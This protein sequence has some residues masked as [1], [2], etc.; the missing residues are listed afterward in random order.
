MNELH[1]DVRVEDIDSFTELIQLLRPRVV[2]STPDHNNTLVF[3]FTAAAHHLGTQPTAHQGEN[4]F[5]PF[6]L[7]RLAIDAKGSEKTQQTITN[8]TRIGGGRVV[9]ATASFVSARP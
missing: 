8:L 3:K 7:V 4:V 6:A 9:S 1:L 5:S 2:F